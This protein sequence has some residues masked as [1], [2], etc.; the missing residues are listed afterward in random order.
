MWEGLK[1]DS[2][3]FVELLLNCPSLGGVPCVRQPF[4]AGVP[5]SLLGWSRPG[6]RALVG[7]RNTNHAV[8]IGTDWDRQEI[9]VFGEIKLIEVPP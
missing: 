6:N 5:A 9:T 7:R 2:E 8:E 3:L 1:P 4:L